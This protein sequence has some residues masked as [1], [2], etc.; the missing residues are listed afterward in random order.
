MRS[1]LA[2]GMVGVLAGASVAVA[3]TNQPIAPP[4]N[5]GYYAGGGYP[6]YSRASTAGESRARGMADVVRSQGEANLNN[7][8]AAVNYSIAQRNEIDNRSAWTS[9]YFQMR[10]E[11]RKARA[12]E[13]GPRA[14]MAD[15]V[16][17]AQAGKPKPLSPGELD[18]VTGTVH[19]PLALQV[20]QFAK[21]RA[22][23]E[24]VFGRRASKGTI[25]PADYMKARQVTQTMLNDLKDQIK[26]IPSEQY[27]V[28]K[29]FLQS[30]A[31]EAARPPS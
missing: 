8:A 11:N 20:E 21:S 7:S 18:V 17:Y 1:L 23:L 15:L 28:A 6:V 24:G 4:S 30:L 5:S 29:N 19:W 25:G 9:T 14:T 16:R 31:Y 2:F 27:M 26:Q 13:R 22:E 12:A 3:Q 10:D